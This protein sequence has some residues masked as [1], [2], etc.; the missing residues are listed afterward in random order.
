MLTDVI[1]NGLLLQLGEE[2]IEGDSGGSSFVLGCVMNNEVGRQAKEEGLEG[3]D[4]S[5]AE[6]LV[7]VRKLRG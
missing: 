6:G 1:V 7:N 3:C 2:F 4:N 5:L